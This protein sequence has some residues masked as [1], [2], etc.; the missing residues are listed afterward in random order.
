MR[1]V[2]GREGRERDRQTDRQTDRQELLGPLQ[3]ISDCL[4]VGWFGW[5]VVNVPATC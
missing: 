2:K 4:F 5:L 1:G 3:P